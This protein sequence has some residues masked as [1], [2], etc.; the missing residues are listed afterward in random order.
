MSAAPFPLGGPRPRDSRAYGF[1]V[2][3]AGTPGWDIGRPQREFV[4]LETRGELGQ[5]VLDVGCGTGENALY[6][7]RRGH[8]VLGVDF[9]PRAVRTARTKAYWRDVEA[10]FLVWDALRL[11]ELGMNFDSAIDSALMHCLDGDERR[12]YADALHATLKPGGTFFALCA[13]APDRAVGEPGWVSRPELYALFDDD[14]QVNY[15]RDAVFETR[16]QPRYRPAYLASV[17]RR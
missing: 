16:G 17:T 8:D 6:L 11:D 2:A 4:G 9:A 15:V 7:A 3:Y 10:Y 5:R 12:Q 14:W 1:D 13:Q